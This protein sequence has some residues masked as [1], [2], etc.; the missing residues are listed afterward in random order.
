MIAFLNSKFFLS[1]FIQ[2]FTMT[3]TYVIFLYSTFP[4]NQRLLNLEKFYL[5]QTYQKIKT[6]PQ[7]P[8]TKVGICESPSPNTIT[9]IMVSIS[10]C[11]DQTCLQFIFKLILNWS[12]WTLLDKSTSLNFHFISLIIPFVQSWK[13]MSKPSIFAFCCQNQDSRL[14]Y[15]N[16]TWETW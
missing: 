8:I 11:L 9:F 13:L 1:T 16:T 5:F 4:M 15:C 2:Y 12:H 14:I 7:V 6:L 10:R 3:W